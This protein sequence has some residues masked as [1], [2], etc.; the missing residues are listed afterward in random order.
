MERHLALRQLAHQFSFEVSCEQFLQHWEENVST[1][2]GCRMV[3]SDTRLGWNPLPGSLSTQA[4]CTAPPAFLSGYFS[5]PHFVFFNERLIAK[6]L[7]VDAM[8]GVEVD[9]SVSLDSNFVGAIHKFMSG[10]SLQE[11]GPAFL[12]AAAYLLNHRIPMDVLPYVCEN[13]QEARQCPKRRTL[14]IRG[15]ASFI[16]FSTGTVRTPRPSGLEDFTFA[17]SKVA[18]DAYAERTLHEILMGPAVVDQQTRL[19]LH[20]QEVHLTLL[21]IAIEYYKHQYASM[22]EKLRWLLQEL[23]T[24]VGRVPHRELMFAYRAFGAEPDPFFEHNWPKNYNRS[25]NIVDLV[26]NMAWDISFYRILE[27]M[28]TTTKRG[29]FFLPFFLTFDRRLAAL[30]SIYSTRLL[31]MDSLDKQVYST[32]PISMRSEFIRAG[33]WESIAEFFHPQRIVAR[34]RRRA[35]YETLFVQCREAESELHRIAHNKPI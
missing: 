34:M 12:E 35:N 11:Q 27:T 6:G 2:R 16:R 30:H 13:F 28:A 17:M 25:K 10:S 9:V 31:L 7:T 21:L 14:V 15:M 29:E 22:S 33:L 5:A 3:L 4:F 1:L 18:A 24:R 23:E 26:R 20:R 8:H 19:L 32:G